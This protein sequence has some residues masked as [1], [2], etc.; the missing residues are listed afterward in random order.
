MSQPPPSALISVTAAVKRFSRTW[1]ALI[2]LVT[3]SPCAVTTVVKF[4]VP[5]RYSLR[6]ISTA[7]RERSTALSCAP[8]CWPSMRRAAIW[9]STSAKAESTTCR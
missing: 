5:A 2:S 8:C 4:C 6:V 9:F 7:L 1:R 3:S